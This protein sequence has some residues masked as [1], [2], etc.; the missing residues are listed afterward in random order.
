MSSSRHNVLEWVTQLPIYGCIVYRALL[1]SHN[2]PVAGRSKAHI[3]EVFDVLSSSMFFSLGTFVQCYLERWLWPMAT[4][5]DQFTL[6]CLFDQRRTQRAW[7]NAERP[8][9][10]DQRRVAFD[11][12]ELASQRWVPPLLS[13]YEHRRQRS[14][15]KCVIIA[16]LFDAHIFVQSQ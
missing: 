9:C 5:V 16:Q 3:K 7:K 1:S 2:V 8:I 12:V 6:L 13:S 14:I 15:S 11:V 10:F 4:V